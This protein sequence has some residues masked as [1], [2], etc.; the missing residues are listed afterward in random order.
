MNLSCFVPHRIAYFAYSNGYVCGNR[1]CLPCPAAAAHLFLRRRYLHV[2]PLAGLWRLGALVPAA[3]I[4]AGIVAL[5]PFWWHSRD[6]WAGYESVF[7]RYPIVLVFGVLV[8]GVLIL[9]HAA[10]RSRSQ[11]RSARLRHDG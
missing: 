5:T 9:A 8:T 2:A 11:D 10:M 7:L 1:S 6:S 4:V 3:V